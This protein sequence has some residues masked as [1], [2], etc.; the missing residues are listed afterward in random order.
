MPNTTQQADLLF[1]KYL[2]VGSSGPQI[3]FF[4]E[5]RQGRSAVFPTQLWLDQSLIP[6][7]ASTVVGIVTQSVDLLLT[8]VPGQTASFYND[9]L[10]DAIPFNYDAVS[11]SYVPT[12]KKSSDNSTIAFGQND[13]VIDVEAGQL[14]FYAGL[15]SGVSGAQPP[16]VTFWKYIGGKGLPTGS[17]TASYVETV[18]GGYF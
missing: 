12:V 15:P 7:T 18:D 6:A 14:T 16:K 4:N 9:Q 3:Q 1:K 5:P 11:G 2:G 10:R 8:Q 13:W 17:T